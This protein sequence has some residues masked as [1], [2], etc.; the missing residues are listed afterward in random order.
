MGCTDLC[1]ANEGTDSKC[2]TVL[3]VE[4]EPVFAAQTKSQA[5]V[6]TEYWIEESISGC[7][8]VT[9]TSGSI[10]VENKVRPEQNRSSERVE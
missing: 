8:F 4:V 3:F 2:V 6:K 10:P 7:M 9:F 1:L 5:I